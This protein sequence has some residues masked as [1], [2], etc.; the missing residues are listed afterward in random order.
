MSHH[1]HYW[2]GNRC[3]DKK[4]NV[5][6]KKEGMKTTK[7]KNSLKRTKEIK[8]GIDE[9]RKQSQKRTKSRLVIK[10]K[11]SMTS[12]TGWHNKSCKDYIANQFRSLKVIGN[13]TSWQLRQRDNLGLVSLKPPSR[14]HYWSIL[15]RLWCL[16]A[17]V[18]AEKKF[19]ILPK[20][21]NSGV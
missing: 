12:I 1:P 17:V 9:K 4:G 13:F 14:A 19:Q 11:R 7:E 5:K 18:S 8:R 20:L 6:R 16:K 21:V 10:M 2:F 15:F 3:I